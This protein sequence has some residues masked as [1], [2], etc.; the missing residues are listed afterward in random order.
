VISAATV[1]SGATQMLA[2]GFM[3]R[4]LK[5]PDT[6]A[7]RQFFGTIGM[8]MVVMG[9]SLL[10]ALLAEEPG[11]SQLAWSAAQKLAASGAVA[12][13][14]RR[15]IFSRRALPVAAFDLV[16]GVVC[17]AHRRRLLD[18]ASDAGR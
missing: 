2:P 12:I 5:C 9:G 7:D 1:A 6:P 13:G 10:H 15:R 8:F 18:A 11:P 4:L 16:S 3:L 14:I 17:L